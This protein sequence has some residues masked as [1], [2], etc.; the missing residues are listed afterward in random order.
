MNTGIN[1]KTE[2]VWFRVRKKE[3]ISKIKFNKSDN[4]QVKFCL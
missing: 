1:N 2:G 3:K 4:I